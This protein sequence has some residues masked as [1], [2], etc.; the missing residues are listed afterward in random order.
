MKKKF[1]PTHFFIHCVDCGTLVLKTD[2][3]EKVVTSLTC[4]FCGQ[5]I[6]IWLNH[7]FNYKT[8]EEMFLKIFKKN[9][10][11]LCNCRFNLL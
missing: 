5:R 3:K 4:Q 10:T 1:I 11:V 6:D 8:N 7:T 2:R 9:Q